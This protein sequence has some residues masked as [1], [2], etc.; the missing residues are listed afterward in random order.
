MTDSRTG[1]G[2][3]QDGP[4]V[5]PESKEGAETTTATPTDEG[6]PKE[7]GGGRKEPPLDKAGTI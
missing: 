6:V 1:A 7:H 3:V 2:S 5:V 4:V